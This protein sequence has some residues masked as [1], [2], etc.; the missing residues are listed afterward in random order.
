[1]CLAFFLLRADPISCPRALTEQKPWVY[2]GRIETPA[3]HPGNSNE[4]VSNNRSSCGTSS[5][6]LP[7]RTRQRKRHS[8]P[9]AQSE[10][11]LLSPRRYSKR[12]YGLAPSCWW[13]VLRR[14]WGTSVVLVVQHSSGRN[15]TLGLAASW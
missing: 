15:P 10:G 9:P 12:G 11:M 2:S 13:P 4:A 6:L 8:R 1:M 5:V 14:Y 3:Q 7:R